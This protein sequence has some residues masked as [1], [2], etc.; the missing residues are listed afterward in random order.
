MVLAARLELRQRQALVITPQLQQAIKLLQL[1]S[2]DL[3]TYIEQEVQ[4]NPLLSLG[5]ADRGENAGDSAPYDAA[6]LSPD[7]PVF[8]GRDAG[9]AING[10]AVA[11]RDVTD[12]REDDPSA[13]AEAGEWKLETSYAA[14]S[15]GRKDAA[16]GLDITSIAAP[17]RSLKDHLRDQVALATGCPADRL[18]ALYLID[19]IEPDGYL[20][21]D[22][23]GIAEALGI[24]RDSVERVLRVLQT[25]EPAG[26]CARDLSECLALQL[27]ERNRLDPAMQTFLKHLDLLAARDFTRLRKI[28]GVDDED[29]EDMIREIRELD[30]RPGLA[31]ERASVAPLI[32]DVLVRRGRN[33]GWQVELNPDTM[34]T[35]NVDRA[36][37]A[38][39]KSRLQG[40]KDRNYLA[41]RMSAANWLAKSLEQRGI[42]ILKV[43]TAIVEAQTPF[44]EKGVRHLKPLNLRQVA[45]KIG[46]HES[47]VSRVTSNKAIATPR[48]V[49]DM[50][51]FFTSSIPSAGPS[52][53]AHSSE[54]VRDRIRELIMNEPP[55]Q[56]LS[57]DRIVALLQGD[58]IDIARRTVA[59]YREA[60][61]I[62]SSAMRRRVKKSMTGMVMAR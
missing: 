14:S 23:P 33:G 53:Q 51:Y 58:G 55:D 49:F 44:L 7:L 46:M 41:E 30:P 11:E 43:A 34:P 24:A 36:Y 62:P 3:Q 17:E 5:E 31:Y 9:G 37:Y 61:R 15:G 57:D 45:A 52:R 32:P 12:H 16:D 13:Y 25:C 40:E 29:L 38:A 1:S 22:L 59:K 42:T 4:Q 35:V 54:A 19:L 56:V 47:T 48:G 6:G 10:E 50:K 60:L 28:C 26:V 21:A 8:D 2:L 39:L 20:R 27:R 18:V